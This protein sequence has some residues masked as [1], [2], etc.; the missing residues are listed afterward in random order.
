MPVL[1]QIIEVKIQG[2]KLC[3]LVKELSGKLKDIEKN[4]LQVKIEND[5][6]MTAEYTDKNPSPIPSSKSKKSSNDR[7]F[8][9]PVDY[10]R[11]KKQSFQASVISVKKV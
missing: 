5:S 11:H 1:S 10:G 7:K 9:I 8:S 4:S 2:K 3:D 6:L